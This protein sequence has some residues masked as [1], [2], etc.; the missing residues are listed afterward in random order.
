MPAD[1]QSIVDA[2][3]AR[4]SA[5]AVAVVDPDGST[6]LHVDA[7]GGD[8]SEHTKFDI[9]SV[10]K[11]F[12]ATLLALLVV[13]GRVSLD[14][15]V[16]DIVDDA[17]AS[18]S[19][20]LGQLATHTSGLPRVPMRLMASPS[21]DI[22]D[23]YRWYM[24]ED[25]LETLRDGP[26]DGVGTYEYSNLGYMVL[27]YLLGIAAGAS[28]G[29]ALTASVL[30]PLGL[31]E[32]VVAESPPPRMAVGYAH[33]AEVSGWSTPLPGASGIYATVHDLAKWVRANIEPDGTP[34]PDAL[35]LAHTPR[36]ETT[37][38]ES[39]CLGWHR[40]EG[41][42][43]HNGGTAG[44][45]AFVGFV[46]EERRGVAIVTNAGHLGEVIDG[47]GFRALGRG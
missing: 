30:L 47:A 2:V 19:I 11:T 3:R 38:S 5:I 27:G 25:L 35:R 9:G 33:N 45:R 28:F 43:W 10:T 20:T 14:T 44:F 31:T 39:V 36:M 37:P 40:R 4:K 15:K 18:A 17:G 32:T 29:E 34:L 6:Q 21:F 42:T 1:P 7:G 24:T 16:G 23:P 46:A 12:T 26:G 8:A 22:Q 13:D 41:A